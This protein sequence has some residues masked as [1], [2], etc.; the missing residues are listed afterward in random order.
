MKKVVL[1]SAVM[2]LMFFSCLSTSSE[3][4]NQE[5]QV[6]QNTQAES[7]DESDSSSTQ[8][9]SDADESD[10]SAQ[11]DTVTITEEPVTE[12]LSDDLIV[13]EKIPESEIQEDLEK[14]LDRETLTEEPVAQ[15]D[16][17]EQESKEESK[18][19]Q[20]YTAQTEKPSEQ[21]K[22]SPEPQKTEVSK[23]E[24]K[25]PDTKSPS[26]EKTDDTTPS[27][28][29]ELSDASDAIN[30]SKEEP[31][32]IVPSREIKIKNNQF[33]D[34]GYPG[35]GWV[36]L[37]ENDRQNLLIFHG[38]KIEN[39][40]TTFTLKSRKSGKAVLHFYKND[41][42]SGKYIDD[43]IEVSIDTESA[44]DNDHVISPEYA[45][46]VP[47]KPEK[48]IP[49]VAQEDKETSEEITPAPA[50][51][52]SQSKEQPKQ[53]SS[54]EEFSIQTII[55]NSD[56]NG[57]GEQSSAQSK[58][59]T[60]TTA[61]AAAQTKTQQTTALQTQPAAGD[62]LEQ[63]QKAYNEK[64]YEDALNLVRQYFVN[65]STRIDE[66]LFLEGQILEAKSPVQNI[67][68]SLKDYETLVSNWPQS[69][70]WKKA[71]DRSVYL[72]RFYI[73]IR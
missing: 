28:Q 59:M 54:E 47:P 23:E 55:Q 27:L 58:A 46:V 62:L 33:L 69:R 65:A 31:A 6:T 10:L 32:P 64:R 9:E 20:S 38:R 51:T 63:A 60:Q 49:A 17:A 73:D 43:Y 16:L 36:Y 70:L 2:S 61:E 72:K 48:V 15:E 56:D 42:L 19:I 41:A 11:N 57:S 7:S 13:Q 45:K 5:T 8:T 34:I 14:L 4:K 71:K 18:E 66:A 39:G 22:T 67:K 37:G 35:T 12:E 24:Q 40:E 53:K 68:E 50:Q 26:S 52:S 29:Q 21:T 44:V 1:F 3:S 30:S 25:K